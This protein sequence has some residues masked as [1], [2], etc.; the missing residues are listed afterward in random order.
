M[1][2]ESVWQERRERGWRQDDREMTIAFSGGRQMRPAVVHGNL[3]EHPLAVEAQVPGAAIKTRPT[4][5]PCHANTFK[6]GDLRRGNFHQFPL[7]RLAGGCRVSAGSEVCSIL[8]LCSSAE[9]GAFYSR[10]AASLATCP[11][12]LVTKVLRLVMSDSCPNSPDTAAV[13]GVV[14][15]AAVL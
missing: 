10:R 1:T 9:Y 8:G 13:R 2:I 4:A 14:T 15:S 6:D 3:C 5:L 11:A 12:R 7:A